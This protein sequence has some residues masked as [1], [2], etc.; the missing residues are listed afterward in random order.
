MI[1]QERMYS[2]GKVYDR[3]PLTHDKL[4]ASPPGQFHRCDLIRPAW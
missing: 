3:M 2:F 4:R 1:E